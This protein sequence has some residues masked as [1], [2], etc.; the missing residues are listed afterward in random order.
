MSEDQQPKF[1]ETIDTAITWLATIEKALA[2]VPMPDGSARTAS[3]I[4]AAAPIIL[5][6]TYAEWTEDVLREGLAEI[7]KSVDN[8][9]DKVDNVAQNVGFL[10]S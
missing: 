3:A 4:A 8:V 6:T 10:Q 7:S 5:Q 2:E 9:A 1:E